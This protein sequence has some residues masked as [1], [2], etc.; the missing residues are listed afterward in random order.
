MPWE[1]LKT[2]LPYLAV[3]VYLLVNTVMS[4]LTV[5]RHKAVALHDRVVEAR[6]LRIEYLKTLES[7]VEDT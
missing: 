1:V 7:V 3:L 5:H 4:V 2:S 6:K